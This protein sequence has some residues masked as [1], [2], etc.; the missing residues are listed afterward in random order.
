MD[1]KLE[2]TQAILDCELLQVDIVHFLRNKGKWN[3]DDYPLTNVETKYI[4]DGYWSH[5]FST[6]VNIYPEDF[7][8]NL[9]YSVLFAAAKSFVRTGLAYYVYDESAPIHVSAPHVNAKN[10]GEDKEIY[11]S[12]LTKVD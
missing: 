3:A 4:P 6:G 2:I 12:F 1:V 9:Y 8:Y 10:K 11:I 5:R 7:D